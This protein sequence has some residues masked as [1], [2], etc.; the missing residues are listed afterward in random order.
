M[1]DEETQKNY[2]DGQFGRLGLLGGT[3]YTALKLRSQGPRPDETNW[4]NCTPEQVAKIRE[5]LKG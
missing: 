5:I 3:Y 4:L 2:I 1:K